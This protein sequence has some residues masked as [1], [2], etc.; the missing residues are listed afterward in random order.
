MPE[1]PKRKPRVYRKR[2]S[3]K[4]VRYY[5]D[6]PMAGGTATYRI[7]EEEFD[8]ADKFGMEKIAHI[9]DEPQTQTS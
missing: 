7:T 2:D 4:N 1:K 5:M 3:E 6:I 9:F 8:R